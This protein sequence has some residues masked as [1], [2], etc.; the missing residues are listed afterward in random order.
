[1]LMGRWSCAIII[2]V[3]VVVVSSSIV[4]IILFTFLKCYYDENG[5]FPIQ[6]ILKHKQVHFMRRKMPFTIN[7][8]LTEREGRTGEYWPEVVTV[9]TEHREVRTKTT[10]GQYSPVR[11]EQARLV[12]SLLYSTGFMPDIFLSNALPVS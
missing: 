6:A 1:M 2:I 3:V 11:F 5:I 12:S 8:L 9:R 10:K 7:L 4:I